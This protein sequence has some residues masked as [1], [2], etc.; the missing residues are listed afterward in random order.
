MKHGLRLK[1]NSPVI[2]GFTAICLLALALDYATQGRSNSLVF[3]TYR[4]SLKDPLTYL[5]LFTHVFGHADW[6]HLISNMSYIL[7]LGPLLEEKYGG[8]VLIVV[9]ALV[10]AST[11]I[12]NSLIFPDTGLLGASGVCFAFILMASITRGGDGEIPLTFILV[13]LIFL[14]QQVYDGI[15]VRDNIANFAHIIGGIVGAT[16]GFAMTGSGVR[17]ESPIGPGSPSGL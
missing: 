13:A 14:G 5:R 9:I 17:G 3:S 4:S 2:L 6:D 12:I 1:F 11:G 10:A 8:R 15:F 7:L 16:A